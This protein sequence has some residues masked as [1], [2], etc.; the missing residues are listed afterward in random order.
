MSKQKELFTVASRDLAQSRSENEQLREEAEALSESSDKV[1]ELYLELAAVKE[2]Y[3]LAQDSLSQ[4]RNENRQLLHDQRNA[5]IKIDELQEEIAQLKSGRNALPHTAQSPDD[6]CYSTESEDSSS[7]L[8]KANVEL[9]SQVHELENFTTEY[10][11]EKRALIDQ[12]EKYEEDLSHADA[13]LKQKS[14][15]LDDALFSLDRERKTWLNE[16]KELTEKIE[17]RSSSTEDKRRGHNDA[18]NKRMRAELDSCQTNMT[19]LKQQLDDATRDRMGL[20]VE[21]DALIAERDRLAS[22]Y[23]HC[24]QKIS[25]LSDELDGARRQL[26]GAKQHESKRASSEMD[27]LRMENTRLRAE[28]QDLTQDFDDCCQKMNDVTN[29]LSRVHLQLQ[30][31]KEREVVVEKEK[32][33]LANMLAAANAKIKELNAQIQLTRKDLKLEENSKA[34]LRQS[35]RRIQELVDSLSEENALLKDKNLSLERASRELQCLLS[36]ANA[37]RDVAY[38]ERDKLIESNSGLLSKFKRLSNERDSAIRE[39]ESVKLRLDKIAAD[40]EADFET[41]REKIDTLLQEKQELLDKVTFLEA[42]KASIEDNAD[43]ILE[44]DN[45]LGVRHDRLK[46]EFKK[47]TLK[48]AELEDEVANLSKRLGRMKSAYDQLSN[49]NSSLVRDIQARSRVDESKGKR[50]VIFGFRGNH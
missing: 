1:E 42:S 40:F 7:D 33:E 5:G 34:Q 45:G 21:N 36:S 20:K 44:R 4:V 29:E 18:D 24:M 30:D 48:V 16:R 11:Q 47:Q 15:E 46:S 35:I 43:R 49:D 22:D 31:S 14:D 28:R 10:N 8:E 32:A 26:N 12:I 2:K 9:Q 25:D 50:R 38:N 23:S 27:G 19:D 3:E 6:M 39:K 37:E 17:S 41:V 13:L